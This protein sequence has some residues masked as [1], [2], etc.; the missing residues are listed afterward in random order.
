MKK[1]L[2]LTLV[3]LFSIT[4]AVAQYA[5]IWDQYPEDVKKTNAFQRFKWQYQQIAFPYDT[6][7][8]YKYSTELKKEINK[9]NSKLRKTDS[10][11]EWSLIGPTGIENPSWSSPHIGVFRVG[12]CVQ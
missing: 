5:S 10:E 7:P 12:E 2:L 6:I 9:I 4:S 3:I 11:I 1:H 8:M